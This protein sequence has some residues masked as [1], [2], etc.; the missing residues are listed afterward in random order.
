MPIHRASSWLLTVKRTAEKSVDSCF[1]DWCC[2]AD[3]QHVGGC[4]SSGMGSMG[5]LVGHASGGG[6]DGD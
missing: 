1:G 2:M 4:A 3:P 5:A 6:S